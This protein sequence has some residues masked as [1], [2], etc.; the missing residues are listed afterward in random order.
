MPVIGYCKDCK[1][2]DEGYFYSCWA[3]GEDHDLAK[4]PKGDDFA[5][6][7]SVLDDSGLDMLVCTGPMF[8]CIK[9]TKAPE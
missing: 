1:Y 9:W 5:I 4:V 7:Y 3:T 6:G 2:W 8:G